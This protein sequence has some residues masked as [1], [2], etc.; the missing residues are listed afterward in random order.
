MIGLVWTQF[1]LSAVK[2]WSFLAFCC[3]F[4][5]LDFLLYRQG[6]QS[7]ICFS[8]CELFSFAMFI[9]FPTYLC[10]AMELLRHTF[11]SYFHV[12]ICIS[13]FKMP[14][15]LDVA[16][17]FIYWSFFSPLS[18]TV[19]VL[20]QV[21]FQVGNRSSDFHPDVRRVRREG[22]YIYEEF[23]PTGGTDVKVV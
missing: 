23:M 10:T 11:Q 5:Y 8:W 15:S 1:S 12:L 2:P 17:V 16:K 14:D 21:S 19:Q 7:I 6:F 13:L 20:D 18:I 3:L 9:Y 4:V 22:S